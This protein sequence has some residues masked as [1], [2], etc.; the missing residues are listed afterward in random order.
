MMKE[1]ILY[2]WRHPQFKGL[3][4]FLAIAMLI[5]T[6]ID[7]VLISFLTTILGVGVENLRFHWHRVIVRDHYRRFFNT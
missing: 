4:I 7:L 1:G 5:A 2:I 3:F 6:S